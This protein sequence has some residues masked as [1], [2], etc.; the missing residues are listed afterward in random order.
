MHHTDAATSRHILK[1]TMNPIKQLARQ[2]RAFLLD[3]L[4]NPGRMEHRP[5]TDLQQ[6]LLSF[7]YKDLIDAKAALPSF[8]DVGFR[9]YSE[10]DEDGILLLIFSIIG[11]KTKKSVELCAGNGI[12]GNT[13]NLIINHGFTGLLI[14]GNKALVDIGSNFY[15]SNPH[16]RFFPPRFVNTWVTREN[17]NSLLESNGFRGEVDL[18]SLD[19]DGMDYWIWEACHGIK[20]RVV[21][22]EYQDILGSERSVTVP[23]QEDFYAYD[24][25]TTK[26]ANNSQMPNYCGASLAAYVKLAK[27]K[28]YRLVGC[29]RYCYN[30]FFIREGVGEESFPEISAGDCFF[31]PK[32]LTQA[33]Q[34]LESVKDLPWA[35]V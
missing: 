25:S 20:P 8:R 30:A 9:V 32:H 28:G 6:L 2:A 13:A 7:R 10:A 3:P 18:F 31:H 27:R 1:A 35:E 24:H 4:L 14:D 5:T 22:L 26:Y 17:I 16:T 15:K 12:D 29:N 21:V 11:F 19:M 23:Y 34:R 33:E